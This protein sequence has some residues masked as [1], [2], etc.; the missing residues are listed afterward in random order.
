MYPHPKIW[1]PVAALGTLVAAAVLA[2]STVTVAAGDT[3]SEIAERNDVT[4][5]ELVEWNDI[6]D[7]DLIFFGSILIVAA[8]HEATSDP[9]SEAGAHIVTAGETLSPVEPSESM[10]TLETGRVNAGFIFFVVSIAITLIFGR[11]FCGWVCHFIAYQDLCRWLLGKTGIKPKPLRSRLLI[12]VPLGLA[13]YMFVW[14]TAYR[15]WVASHDP[16]PAK[17]RLSWTA[18]LTTE[19]FWQTFPGIG[20]AILTVV[21]AGFAVV[22]FLGSK[23]FCTYGCPYGAFYGL[24]D[25]VAP[26][27]VRVSDA[28]DGSGVCTSV[29]TSNVNVASEV[30]KYGMVVHPGCMKCGDC[31]SACPNDALRFGFG[32]PAVAKAKPAETSDRKST[33]LNSSHTDISR[34]PSSA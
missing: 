5:A 21:V 25:Q 18:H 10:E 4:I 9:V 31:I 22:Y 24:A 15:W 34:M 23:G 17:Y 20:F 3:L 6:D 8:P 2:T 29:C 12:F 28:C 16:D 30:R 13:L 26:M 33:R 32:K 19:H 7:A 1:R 11:F 14:P 27:R